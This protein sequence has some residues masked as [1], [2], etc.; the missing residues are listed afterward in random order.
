[1]KTKRI[2]SL[3]LVISI[4]FSMTPS[5]SVNAAGQEPENTAATAEGAALGFLAAACAVSG[6]MDVSGFAFTVVVKGTVLRLAVD[7]DFRT[8]AAGGVGH[9][10]LTALL[11]ALAARFHGAFGS[12]SAYADISFGTELVLVV[13][14][15]HSGTT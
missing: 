3:L 7:T 13:N 15:G 10:A 1:M 9:R 8:A 2:I 4:I 6:D 12:A 5:L 11:E 14:T